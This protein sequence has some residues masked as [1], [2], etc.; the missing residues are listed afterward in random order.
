MFKHI[1]FGLGLL[2]GVKHALAVCTFSVVPTLGFACLP[3]SGACLITPTLQLNC[4][5]DASPT[6]TLSTGNSGSFS[7]RTMYDAAQNLN[8]AYNVYLDANYSQ[9]F[10]TGSGG[11]G[12]YAIQNQLIHRK[13][14]FVL[15]AKVP[16][17]AG[18]AGNYTDS[19]VLTMT[20]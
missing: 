18:L 4:N 12:T 9:I 14:N 20:Y 5:P 13:V 10:G 6:V 15:Y 2:L 17:T 16:S 19:L 7:A 11:S 3:N 8:L 1:G